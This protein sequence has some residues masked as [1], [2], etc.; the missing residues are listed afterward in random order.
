MV[1]RP[2]PLPKVLPFCHEAAVSEYI[3][4]Q[5]LRQFVQI[6]PN[7]TLLQLPRDIKPISVESKP[8]GLQVTCKF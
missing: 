1:A 7:L 5:L 6:A 4:G 2:L 3:R 8:E